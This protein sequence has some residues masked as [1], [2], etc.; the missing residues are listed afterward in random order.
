MKKQ[1]FWRLSVAML[2]GL[3]FHLVGGDVVEAQQ[4]RNQQTRDQQTYRGQQPGGATISDGIVQIQAQMPEEVR[5]GER[6]DYRIVVTNT[7]DSLTVHDLKLRQAEAAGFSVESASMEGE[8]N[9]DM[10]QRDQQ[11]NQQQQGQQQQDLQPQ[12]QQQQGQQQQG[13]QQQDQQ[14][15]DRAIEEAAGVNDNASPQQ[16][17]RGMQDQLGERSLHEGGTFNVGTL[18]PGES[19]TLVV[20]ASADQ[21]GELRSCLELV[22]YTPA[23]C[24][25]AR[26]VR[27][28]LEIAKTAPEE[29]NICEIIVMRYTVTNS[30]TG[31]IERFRIVDNLPEGLVTIDGNENLDFEVDGLAAGQSRAFEGRLLARRTGEFSS[32]ALAEATEFDLQA[33]SAN[34]TTRVVGAEL[35]ARVEG[36][37][38]V[39]SGQPATFVAR[40][41]NTGDYTAND[42]RVVVRW[43][44]QARLA[45]LTDPR[46]D[47]DAQ[48]ADRT[49]ENQMG[50]L[51]MAGNRDQ[52]QPITAVN[53]NDNGV[54]DGNNND[55]AQNQEQNQEQDQGREDF[56]VAMN[57]EQFTIS[58]LEP[59]HTA[60]FRYVI[61]PNGLTDLPTEIV[62]EYVCAPDSDIAIDRAEAITMSRAMASAEVIRLAALRIFTVDNIDPVQRGQEVTYTVVVTNQGDAPDSNV[63]IRAELPEGLEFV[64][65][66]GP[67]EH[68]QEERAIVFDPVETLEPGADARYTITATAQ[69]DRDVIFRA[70]LNSDSLRNEV[71]SEEPTRLFSSQETN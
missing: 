61:Q 10:Q 23:I 64:N 48:A 4:A 38:E 63:E 70:V 41:T 68:R 32:R 57:E 35:D 25:M 11:Q 29:V 71:A 5:A 54:D 1:N 2:T 19:R 49:R 8:D 46:I 26:V 60:T 40:V 66:N 65:A 53:G 69:E 55:Q 43:P 51:A 56:D 28:E 9:Q 22:S 36:P 27:P 50:S 31:D 37:N 16:G 7:S 12:G 33:R 58:T 13:Q 47:Q 15:Q 42:V 39:Y 59:N 3:S 21:E 18:N 44:A 34:T 17:Q 20:A 24:L 67:T 6:F 62:A 52:I 30:G 45:R 14:Q